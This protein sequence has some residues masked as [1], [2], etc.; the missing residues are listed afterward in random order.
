MAQTTDGWYVGA[1]TGVN[2]VPTNKLKT[3]TLGNLKETND[4]GYVILGEVGYGI[5]PF[6][7]EAEVGWR[8]NDV[9]KLKSAS[10]ATF[11]G[12]RGSLN[13]L[14]GMFNGYYD[15]H[16]GTPFTP[17]IGAGLGVADVSAD[18]IRATGATVSNDDK[19]TFAYQGIA[20]VSYAVSDNLG[21]KLDYHYLR[22]NPTSL[23]EDSSL[24]DVAGAKLKTTYASHAVL[25]GF[26]YKFGQPAPAPVA[27]A[28]P[29]MAPAPAPVPKPVQAAP[30]AKSFQVFFDFDKS[31]ITADAA[32][33]IM[34]AAAAAKANNSTTITCVGHTD[35][36]GTDKYNM[37]LSLRRANAVKAALIKQGIPASE[38]EV[39]G[40]G[41]SDLLVPTADGVREPQNRR[42]Q[43]VL[44]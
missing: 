2:L 8:G 42:V 43:I 32:R 16:T 17:F 44:P 38:I 35:T 33:I 3:Q 40:K 14:S 30:I 11:S 20:G 39:V 5:G 34:Q 10:N 19:A 12:S 31:N 13:L 26:I 24:G 29:V 28:A 23:R 37:A 4:P 1:D 15:I 25:V 18:K 6:R 36:V 9:D 22:T 21:I 27:A 41:K 7:A